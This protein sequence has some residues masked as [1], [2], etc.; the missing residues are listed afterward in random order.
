MAAA[1]RAQEGDFP[2]WTEV[3]DWAAGIAAAP[4]S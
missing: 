3:R 1:L 4:Q 2:D